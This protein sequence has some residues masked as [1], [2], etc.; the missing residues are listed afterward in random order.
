MRL[1][2]ASRMARLFSCTSCAPEQLRARSPPCIRNMLEMKLLPLLLLPFSLSALGQV[3]SWREGG[4]MRISNEPPARYRL[5]EPVRG[6][7]IVVTQGRRIIDDT[8][9]SMEE[10]RRLRPQ[11]RLQ[12]SSPARSPVQN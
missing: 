10:R 2:S 5:Y 7:R 12:A 8:A 9:L 6:P 1:K 3:Y 4:S 11:V